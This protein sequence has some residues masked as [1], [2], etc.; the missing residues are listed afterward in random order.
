MH[1]DMQAQAADSICYGTTEKGRLENGVQLPSEGRNFEAYS[2]LGC[3]LGRTYVHG[4]VRE[5][6]VSAYRAL[7]VS[8]PGK[9]FVYGETGWS[10]GGTFRPHKTHENGL[11]VD[12]MVP[13][14][15][16]TGKS[17]PLPCSPFNKFGYNIE[18]DSSGRYEEYTIDFEAMAEHIY[19]VHMA[20]TENGIGIFRVI[21]D[22]ALQPLL[23]KTKRGPY[24]QEHMTFSKKPSWVR[25]DEHYHIDFSVKCKPMEN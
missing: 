12:F 7:E 25:H 20:A 6:V 14:T 4:K 15:A 13:V 17:I 2:R 23:F 18:L 10:S 9:I 8:A 16:R 3:F 22:S 5:V 24:I 11:S 21:F 1:F 19:Q